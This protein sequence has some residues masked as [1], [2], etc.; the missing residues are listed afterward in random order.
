[1]Q[2]GHARGENERGRTGWRIERTDQ[3]QAVALLQPRQPDGFRDHG[4]G[5]VLRVHEI[6]GHETLDLEARISCFVGDDAEV[7]QSAHSTSVS[8]GDENSASGGVAHQGQGVARP[9]RGVDIRRAEGRD[10]ERLVKLR[11]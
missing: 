5:D 7:E 9:K 1:M 8:T 4:A 10:H 11:G 3:P 6:E 2:I